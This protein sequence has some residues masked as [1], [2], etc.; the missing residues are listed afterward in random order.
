MKRKIMAFLSLVLMGA[1]V[2]ALQPTPTYA[3]GGGNC[4]KDAVLGF[5]PWYAGLCYPDGSG[6]E[7]IKPPEKNDDGND[8]VRFV[9]TIVL[10][11][12]FDLIL[13]VGYLAIGFVVYGGYMVMISQGDPSKLAKGKKTLT[14]AV[15]GTVITMVATVA[16]NTIRVILGTNTEDGW[17]QGVFTQD[18]VTAILNWAYIVAGIVAVIFIVKGGLEY[19]IS[20]GDPGKTRKATQEIIYAIVGLVIVLL[21]AVIT[22]FVTS[23]TG[24]ALQ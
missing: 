13:A 9:W 18:N 17:N 12:L 21:A 20:N 22:G 23:T 8:L 19:M 14:S 1:G 5:R 3:L 11:V 2:L 15:I 7:G 10:N 6:D 4:G 24:G 16:V